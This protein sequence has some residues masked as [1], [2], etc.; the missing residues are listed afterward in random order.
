MN[1][2]NILSGIPQAAATYLTR[3]MEIKAEDRQQERAIKRAQVERQIE[4][5]K[6]GRAADATW[7]LESL[8]A[9]AS[10]WKD[11]FILILLSIPLILVFFPPTAP[12]VLTGFKILESTPSWYRWL[13][14]LIFTAVY[15][16]RI[17]R[18]QQSDT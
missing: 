10:G 8:K 14:L 5:V 16:I 9:H 7:E 2:L 18:R 4:L 17:W 13:I 3:R 11:E 12:Y 1:L 15:G 6:E